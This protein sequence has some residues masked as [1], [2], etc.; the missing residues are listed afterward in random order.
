R[1]RRP[2]AFNTQPK[3]RNT[4]LCS[5]A[6]CLRLRAVSQGFSASL[7]YKTMLTPSCILKHISSAPLPLPH[8]QCPMPNAQCP[9]PNAQCPMLNAQCPMPNA[10]CPMPNA[11]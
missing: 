3:V 6:E 9:M 7:S 8:A 10:Q 11:Q 5:E 1:K 2:K 4:Q